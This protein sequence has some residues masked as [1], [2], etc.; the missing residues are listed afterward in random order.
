MTSCLSDKEKEMI[1]DCDGLAM[2]SYRGLPRPAK[3]YKE[4]CEMKVGQLEYSPEVCKR[5]MG[6]F[7]LNGSRKRLSKMFGNRIM[8]CFNKVDIERF[9]K[10]ESSK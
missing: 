6:D 5:A 1:K 3:L 2:K 4:H 10:I 7:M 8:E 9:E